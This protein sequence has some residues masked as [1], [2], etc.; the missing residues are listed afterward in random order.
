MTNTRLRLGEILIDA[1]MLRPDQL[2]IALELQKS[3]GL[4]LGQ[5]LLQE[6]FV[7][8]PQLV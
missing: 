5:I 6:G 1:G 2:D 8:E 3:R 4:R 7:S